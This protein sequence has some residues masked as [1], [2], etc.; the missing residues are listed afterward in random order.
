M[1]GDKREHHS[2]F[3]MV[4]DATERWTFELSVIKA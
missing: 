4:T 1:S 3:E 2:D